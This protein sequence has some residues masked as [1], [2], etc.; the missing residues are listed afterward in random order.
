MT[1]PIQ[2]NKTYGVLH[3]ENYFSFVGFAKKIGSDDIQKVDV[4]LDNKLIDT[5]EAKEFIQKLD[6][7]YDV[8]NQAFSYNLPSKYIGQKAKI[9]FKNHASKEELLNS[10]YTLIDKSHED[11]NEAKFIHSLNEPISEELKDMYKPN[12]IGFLA[13]KENLEDEEFVGYIKELIERFPE[14]KINGFCINNT[15][16]NISKNFINIKYISTLQQIIDTQLFIYKN[17]YIQIQ[18]ANKISNFRTCTYLDFKINDNIK[19]YE[20]RF[21]DYFNV[22]F[23]NIEKF[24]FTQKDIDR[25]DKSFFCIVYNNFINSNNLKCDFINLNDNYKL[26]YFKK[27][28]IL[29]NSNHF[30]DYLLNITNILNKL[31]KN[32]N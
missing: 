23:K 19:L 20:E 21:K 11:F 31:N 4:Y 17:S 12:S 22:F 13:T 25:Y 2:P 1:S 24:G 27:I 6:D 26:L 28:E 10:P 29:L 32:V 30:Q 14:M 18:I 9:S 15:Q 8:E 7:M 5:I 3:T 16:I